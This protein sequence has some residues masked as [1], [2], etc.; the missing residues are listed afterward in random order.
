[1]DGRKSSAP[2]I[3]PPEH[4]GL[5]PIQASIPMHLGITTLDVVVRTAL[6]AAA[7]A[8]LVGKFGFDLPPTRVFP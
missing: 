6:P 1:M 2:F 8:V 5:T 4:I 7:L 3:L